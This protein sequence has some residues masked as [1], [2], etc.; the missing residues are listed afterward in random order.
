MINVI[1]NKVV[2][3]ENKIKLFEHTLLKLNPNNLLV[4]GYT[5]LE[6]NGLPVKGVDE[7]NTGDDVTVRLIDGKITAQVSK[8]DKEIK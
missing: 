3:F 1:N 4:K 2:N 5:K 7:V 8:V 6:I